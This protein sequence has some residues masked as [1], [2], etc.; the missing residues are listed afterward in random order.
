MCAILQKKTREKQTDT[1]TVLTVITVLASLLAADK[2]L[3]I[4]NSV[5]WI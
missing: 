2:L 4:A 5:L 3:S 1:L